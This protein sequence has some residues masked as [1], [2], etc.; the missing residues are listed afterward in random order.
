MTVLQITDW[1]KR[2]N[3]YGLSDSVII[4]LFI[5]SIISIIAEIISIGIFLPL[6]ELIEQYD[7]AED[8]VNS[9]SEIAIYINNII[10]FIGL[11]FTIETLLMLSF[12]LFLFSKILLYV[13]TYMQSYYRGLIIKKNKDRLLSNYL[14]ATSGYYD[15]VG[16]GDF[17]NSSSVELPKAMSGAMLPIKLIITIMSGVG[18]IVVLFAISPK[19]TFVSICVVG[20]GALLPA[21]WVKATT[22]A[23]KKNSRY[24]SV[25]TSFLLNR[26]QSPRLVR[27]SNTA[28]AEEKSYF[29]LTEK[30]R[31]LTLAI[32]LLKARITLTLEPIIIGISLSMFYVA[33]V[34]IKMPISAVLLYMIVMIR[35][36]PIIS[37]VLTQKQSM[38]RAVGPIQVIDNLLSDMN[39]NINHRKKNIVDNELINRIDTL[40][41]DSVYYHYNG[42]IDNALSNINHTFKKST[43]TAI[44]G[45]SGSGKS[46]F[47]DIVS[48]YREPTSGTLFIDE[49]KADKYNTEVLMSLISYVAQ[50]P[51]IFDD[52]TVYEH[53]AYGGSNPTKDEVI[54]AS[55]LSGAYDFIK[56]L[57]QEFDT[58][59]TGSSSGLSGGQ[60]Q[61]LDLSRALLRDTPVLIMDEPT[62]NLDL[63]SEK[64]LML[65][66]KK[67]KETTGAVIIIIA[68]RL[69][70]IADADQIIVL[71]NGKISGLGTHSELLLSN[72][73]YK[74]AVE[75]L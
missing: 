61:R 41:L 36:V 44:V 17:T 63:V 50:D 54:N 71:E 68:H 18:S 8:L 65:N 15:S 11:S 21:R 19:L 4:M 37:E 73:W 3:N 16:I 25:L 45:P 28:N 60:K 12:M 52:I 2:L 22:N 47:V 6:F 40:R 58:V 51:Q 39:T 43:L 46:T 24:N 20:V 57:P 55:K 56:E 53:I 7:G 64:E 30:H 69:Y 14:Q 66:I 10:R 23:G 75:E 49:I 29:A 26:L 67:I 32:Q 70:T 38:N 42:C 74:K 72:S 31:K 48:G 13:I 59:L 34:V 62:G 9:K 35:I 5:I 27:L 1:K 33:L